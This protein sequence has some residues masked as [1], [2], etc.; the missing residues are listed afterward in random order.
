MRPGKMDQRVTFQ[1]ETRTADNMGG[2][3]R[4]WSNFPSTPTVWAR[5]IPQRGNET[6]NGERVD[7]EAMFTFVIRNRTDVS[8]NDR[9]VWRGDYYNIRHIERRG[10]RELYLYINAERGVAG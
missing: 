1:A 2:A 4:T 6:V 9:M 10:T 5:V 8:E 7:A 3:V